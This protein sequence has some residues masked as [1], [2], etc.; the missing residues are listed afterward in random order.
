MKKYT[1]KY[2]LTDLMSFAMVGFEFEFYS[3]EPYYKT[4][5]LLNMVLAPVQVWGFREYHSNFK[6]DEKNYKI[7]P[8]HSGGS[9]MIELV[10]GPIKYTDSKIVLLKVLKYIQ[11][12]GYTNDKCSVHINISFNR[13]NTK[14]TIDKVNVLKMILNIDEEDIYKKFPNRQNN[15]YAKSVKNVMPYKQYD[16]VSTALKSIQNNFYTPEEKYYGVNFNHLQEQEDARIEYRYIGGENY[17]FKTGEILDLLDYFISFSWQNIGASLDEADVAELKKYFNSHINKYKSFSSYDKFLASYPH[18]TISVN[19][20]YLYDI[21]NA[22]Y[23]KFYDMLYDLFSSIKTEDNIYVNY[24]SDIH[25]LEIVDLNF[26][27]ILDIKNFDFIDCDIQNSMLYNCMIVNSNIKNCHLVDCVVHGSDIVNS[28]I[29]ESTV[30]ESSTMLD[31]FFYSGVIN[32]E[33]SGGVFRSGT[34]G[35]NA[36]IKSDVKIIKEEEGFFGDSEDKNSKKK[37]KI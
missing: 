33:M 15:I 36:F 2:N 5:E 12:R 28:K 22:Y 16:Y 37:K 11:Q 20:N 29:A 10:T 26:E 6:T 34:I 23:D 24:V 1:D 14:K 13:D 21:V 3:K 30:D 18:A 4:L 8:D 35:D 27:T 9:N 19:N 7:E 32:A 17:E 25:K 31:C